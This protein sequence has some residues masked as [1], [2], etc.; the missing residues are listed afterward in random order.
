M[1]HSKLLQDH[2]ANYRIVEEGK[3]VQSDACDEAFKNLKK[4]MTTSPVLAQP[5]MDKTF[6]AYYF[7]SGTSFGGVLMLEGRVISYSS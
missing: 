6:D 1:V 7:A 4:L 5:D 3:H 2:E